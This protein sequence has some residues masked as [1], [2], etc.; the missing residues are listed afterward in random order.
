MQ[1]RIRLLYAIVPLAAILLSFAITS[2]S[3]A[4]PDSNSDER[5]KRLLQRAPQADANK[6]GVLTRTEA[7]AFLKG[8]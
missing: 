7:Q 6:D 3:L 4:E 2:T 8:V 1:N 5:L